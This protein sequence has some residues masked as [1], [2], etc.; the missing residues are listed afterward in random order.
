MLQ[1]YA[2]T[3][4]RRRAEQWAESSEWQ[5]QKKMEKS[6]LDQQPPTTDRPD[7]HQHDQHQHTTAANCI[8][9]TESPRRTYCSAEFV[10]LLGPHR[11][12]NE[13]QL[14]INQSR[15]SNMF[16]NVHQH[17]VN[18]NFRL[19]ECLVTFVDRFCCPWRHANVMSHDVARH[20]CHK[21]IAAEQGA[22]FEAACSF[23]SFF[24]LWKFE[25]GGPSYYT[26]ND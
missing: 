24:H 13:S 14:H 6:L 9:M 26:T 12:R 10:P 3:N 22:Y 20:A 11:A 23:A 18:I 19:E 16:W 4:R 5:S 1:S 25:K 17:S 15:T 2:S 21:E 8:E 7:Q